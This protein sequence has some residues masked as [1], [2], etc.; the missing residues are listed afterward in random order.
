[1]DIEGGARLGG[2]I[3]MAVDFGVGILREERTYKMMEGDSLCR[4]A[5]VLG[6]HSRITATDVA[7]AN[8]AGVMTRAMCA[9]M[10]DGAALVNRAVKINEV[11]IANAEKPTLAVPSVDIGDGHGTALGRG[12]AVDYYFCNFAHS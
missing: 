9:R 7:H 5:R 8:G 4:S 12:G 3:T 2:E 11:M 10:M 6:I 1:M